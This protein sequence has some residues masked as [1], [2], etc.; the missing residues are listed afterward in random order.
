MCPSVTKTIPIIDM[1]LLGLGFDPT[2]EEW[3]RVGKEICTAFADIGFLYLKGHGLNMDLVENSFSASSKFFALDES[4][5]LGYPRD[6]EKQQGY[7]A[8]DREKLDPDVNKH[9][10]RESYDV[11]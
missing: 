9:E 7:V 11:K 3:Q 4:I 6:P 10:L 2:K 1:G 5:K 8:V